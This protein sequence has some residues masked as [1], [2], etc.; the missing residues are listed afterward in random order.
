[1]SPEFTGRCEKD[2]SSRLIESS[3]PSLRWKYLKRNIWFKEESGC[4]T[5]RKKVQEDFR[6]PKTVNDE[7]IV[8]RVNY[9][10]VK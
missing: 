6:E 2:Y 1:M 5:K 3:G 9:R 8:E 10:E 7:K 4:L